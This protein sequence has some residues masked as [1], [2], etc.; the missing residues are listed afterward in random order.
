M[1]GLTLAS[2]LHDKVLERLEKFDVPRSYT[3]PWVLYLVCLLAVD[4]LDTDEEL[5]QKMLEYLGDKD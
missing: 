1:Q 4:T 3:K 5:K 2:S